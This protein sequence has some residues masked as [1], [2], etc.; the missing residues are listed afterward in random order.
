[1]TTRIQTSSDRSLRLV[2]LKILPMSPPRIS[3]ASGIDRG[4]SSPDRRA[5]FLKMGS[6]TVMITKSLPCKIP[7]YAHFKASSRRSK[8]GLRENIQ[9]LNSAT[10]PPS[11][12]FRCGPNIFEEERWSGESVEKERPK[13]RPRLPLF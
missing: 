5:L 4:E 11:F 2:F 3:T 10:M 13:V 1:M 6:C 8:K 9:K 7:F 12:L